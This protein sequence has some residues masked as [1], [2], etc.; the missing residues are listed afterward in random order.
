MQTIEIDFEVFKELTL[1]RKSE[2]ETYN[3]VL[4]DLLKLSK[5]KGK[6]DTLGSGSPWVSKNVVFPHGTDFR[7]VYKG[8]AYFGKVDNGALVING[9]R[10]TAP[11]A[12][13]VSITNNSINGWN[14][15][16]CKLPGQSKW[17]KINKLRRGV[18]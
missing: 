13:A 4:R 5:D 3:D 8:Q 17:I 1:R 6:H 10:F 12:A 9:E 7:G 11:S 15:W 18:R 2:E 14:F 16:E